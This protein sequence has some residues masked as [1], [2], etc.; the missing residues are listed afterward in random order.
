MPVPLG[1]E[2]TDEFD[3]LGVLKLEG[4]LPPDRVRPVRDAVLGPLMRAGLW[5][6][7]GWRLDDVPIPKWPHS[8]AA[9]AKLVGGMYADIA[10][11][12]E[13][14]AHQAVAEALMS[15]QPLVA[16]LIEDPALRAVVD[17]LLGGP[18]IEKRGTQLLFTLPNTHTWTLPNGWHA[19]VP[20]LAS[21]ERPGVFVFTFLDTVE[22]RG[23]GTL[24]V[25]GSHR[26]LDCGRFIGT[27]EF[28]GLLSGAPFIC[29]L[30]SGPPASLD[31]QE[32]LPAGVADGVSL[33]IIELTGAPGDVWLVD[34]R[35]LHAVAPNAAGRPR[36]MA[37]DRLMRADLQEELAGSRAGR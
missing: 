32:R 33:Q 2:E 34:A 26:L 7:D 21:G 11:L 29:E 6:D 25:A 23:G 22:P 13:H 37:V 24:V 5:T 31:G 16:G 36:M 4:L 14:P 20:R 15:G 10:V 1:L 3:R 19:D 35:C 12:M 8:G 17:A 18:F 28:Q 27:S 9:R 30:Y